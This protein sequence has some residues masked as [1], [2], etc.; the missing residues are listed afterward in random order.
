MCQSRLHRVVASGE[1]S[2]VRVVDMDGREHSVSPRR[3]EGKRAD[4]P[5]GAPRATARPSVPSRSPSAPR[6]S[7]RSARSSV[8]R[9]GGTRLTS[10]KTSSSPSSKP[11]SRR[12][13]CRCQRGEPH[14]RGERH[15]DRQGLNGGGHGSFLSI[16]P[17]TLRSAPTHG[18]QPHGTHQTHQT[19][20]DARRTTTE[21]WAARR[22]F[23]V[24]RPGKVAGRT[25]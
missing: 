7:G 1:D 13:P 22:R 8:T 12:H 9:S 20:Q 11:G 4:D 25:R 15:R 14:R 19:H 2:T 10:C 18:A 17:S 21:P 3:P 23:L 6:C 16:G 24:S 5:L